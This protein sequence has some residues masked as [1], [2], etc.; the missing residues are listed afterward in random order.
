[1]HKEI[2]SLLTSV[3]KEGEKKETTKDNMN[4]CR[5]CGQESNTRKKILQHYVTQ[6]FDK[7]IS[8]LMIFYINDDICVKCG[9]E[10]ESTDKT[11]R[12]NSKLNHIGI[13]HKVVSTLLQT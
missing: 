12:Y 5:I 6:H 10:F 3:N 7:E 13:F 4:K 1:M 11:E 8:D 9:K 2:F